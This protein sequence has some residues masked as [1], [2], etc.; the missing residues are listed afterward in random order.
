MKHKFI[1]IPLLKYLESIN[2][3]LN[4]LV[5]KHCKKPLVDFNDINDV[6]VHVSDKNVYFY[7]NKKE[8]IENEQNRWLIRGKKING[9]IYRREICWDCFFEK[10]NQYIR[11]PWHLKRL[12]KF[13]NG[14]PW[15]RD[16]YN[17]IYRVPL[18]TVSFG[19]NL[20]QFLFDIPKEELEKQRKKYSTAS[21]EYWINKLGKVEGTKRYNEIAARQGY[22]ASSKY[23]I[24]ERCLTP[25]EAENFHMNRA[26]TKENFIKRYG[27]EEGLKYWA[28][29]CKHE[30]WA[31]CALD[32]FITKF[33]PIEG[34]KRYKDINKLKSPTLNNFIRKYGEQEGTEKYKIYNKLKSKSYSNISQKLFD[35][36]LKSIEDKDNVFY[37]SHNGEVEI[38]AIDS[39]KY[40][41]ADFKYHNKIIEFNGTYW[42]ADPRL[43]DENELI[44]E[45]TL[46]KDIHEHDRIKL[47]EFK[48]Q[49]YDV[50]VIWESDYMFD[51]NAVINKCLEFLSVKA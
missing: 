28:E 34:E 14:K 50:L 6:L 11:D 25:E 47:D 48:K 37:G 31:G 32:Y 20:N 27:K 3:D 24:E 51:Q 4:S 46:A 22:T 15:H 21:K 33:G 1:K 2:V 35:E 49:G 19:S 23:L 13:R 44:R 17:G 45:N 12:G 9:K 40:Y 7:K 5:C 18:P 10:V 39:E 16:F 43:Y 41:F 29:Y 26:S 42:H 36:L 8:Y 38:D 30:A